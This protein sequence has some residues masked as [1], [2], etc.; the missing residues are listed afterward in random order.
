M[1]PPRVNDVSARRHQT[2]IEPAN[3]RCL[4]SA[5]RT[6]RQDSQPESRSSRS[7]LVSRLSTAAAA[8]VRSRQVMSCVVGRARSRRA[9]PPATDAVPT[10][11]PS[12]PPITVLP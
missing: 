3:C 2:L 7:E 6:V 11:V 10:H 12:G 9:A 4:A 5:E 8:L 1:Q